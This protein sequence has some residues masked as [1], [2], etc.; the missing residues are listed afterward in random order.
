MYLRILQN[1]VV[2]KDEPNWYLIIGDD[3]SVWGE[4]HRRPSSREFKAQMPVS[5]VQRLIRLAEDMGQ[6]FP[7]VQKLESDD[8]C[9]R[10]LKEG[11][12]EVYSYAVSP[13]EQRAEPAVAFFTVVKRLLE[14]NAA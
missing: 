2:L 8:I 4:I 3:G 5:D 9:V 1:G 10:V 6:R 11:G 13:S 7:H 14:T 12:V